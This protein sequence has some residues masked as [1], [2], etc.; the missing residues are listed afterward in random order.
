MNR[1]F[2]ATGIAVGLALTA[3]TGAPGVQGT[4]TE[5]EVETSYRNKKL[6]TCYELEILDTRGVEHDF[7]VT[8]E[9]YD[10]YEVGD[11]YPRG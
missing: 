3:C 10:K 6:E 9:L 5:K 11:Q 1:L 4:V 7:C 8:K 2:V